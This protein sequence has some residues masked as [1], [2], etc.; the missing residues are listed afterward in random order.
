M[1]KKKPP[2]PLDED[3]LHLNDKP[4]PH[5]PTEI[6][7]SIVARIDAVMD[8][9]A[10]GGVPYQQKILL[11]SAEMRESLQ[12][13]LESIEVDLFDF[14][15][16]RRMELKR[17]IDTMRQNLTR[18][19]NEDRVLEAA[20]GCLKRPVID[21]DAKPPPQEIDAD[22]KPPSQEILEDIPFY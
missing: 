1:A 11:E 10:S 3:W 18:A 19:E 4:V 17:K 15:G 22:A 9:M 2:E 12:D 14:I 13:R 5:S 20:R 8:I 16:K 21:A 6:H 7:E